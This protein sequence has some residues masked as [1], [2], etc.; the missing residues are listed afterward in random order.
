MTRSPACR[1]YWVIWD[2]LEVRDDILYK[3]FLKRDGT[4]DHMQLLVPL[5]LKRDILCQMHDSLVSG[6][7]GC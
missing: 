4:G 2:T 5:A 7:L 3:K 1:H 6:H